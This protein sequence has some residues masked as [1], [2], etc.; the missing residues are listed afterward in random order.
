MVTC[1]LGL[2]LSYRWL[3]VC[4]CQWVMCC[5]AQQASEKI[6]HFRAHA[7]QVFMTLLHSAGPAGPTVPHVPHRGELEKLFPRY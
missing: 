7:A 5:L 2:E 4:S 3:L 1:G 6:D